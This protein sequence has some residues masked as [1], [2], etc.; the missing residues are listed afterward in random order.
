MDR[1]TTW[2]NRSLRSIAR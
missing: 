2:H 1:Q